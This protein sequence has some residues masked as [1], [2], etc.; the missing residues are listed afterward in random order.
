MKASLDA[1]SSLYRLFKKMTNLQWQGD[2]D[3]TRTITNG[4]NP[5]KE[6]VYGWFRQKAL[7]NA[8][9]Q[10]GEV[11]ETLNHNRLFYRN[12]YGDVKE[13]IELQK[14][15]DIY[16]TSEKDYYVPSPGK[17]IPKYNNSG[18]TKV[19][20]IFYNGPEGKSLHKTFNTRQAAEKFRDEVNSGTNPNMTNAHTINSLF[21]LHSALGG[22]DCVN[23]RGESSEFNNEVV[24]NYMNEV[25]YLREDGP[26]VKQKDQ[27]SYI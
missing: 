12:S 24:V 11:F 17:P 10:Y 2:V 14:E 26:A 22:I 9:V 5:R 18:I 23:A 21:E 3:L 16:Y 1:D 25:G 8:V 4:K 13:I 27:A 20:H 7:G 19:Y 6:E 15:G